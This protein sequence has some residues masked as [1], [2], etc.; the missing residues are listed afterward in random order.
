M[1]KFKPFGNNIQIKPV[2]KKQIAVGETQTIGEYGEVTAVGED[3]TKVKVGDTLVYKK[4]GLLDIVVDDT[5]YFFIPEDARFI[6][7]HYDLGGK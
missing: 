6:M 7:A 5:V 2:E 3:V 4:Y 1:N